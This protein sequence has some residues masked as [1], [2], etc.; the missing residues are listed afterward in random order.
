MSYQIRKGKVLLTFLV[1]GGL[2]RMKK[3]WYMVVS[4][5]NEIA[6]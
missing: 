4:I 3:I 1:G 2:T 5:T 6:K